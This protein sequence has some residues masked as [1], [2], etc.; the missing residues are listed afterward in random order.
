MSPKIHG[1]WMDTPTGLPMPTARQRIEALADLD[2]HM[3]RTLKAKTCVSCG[4]TEGLSK[5]Q[6]T[7]LPSAYLICEACS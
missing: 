7:L 2:Q 6:A 1:P 5:V 4:A 3:Y